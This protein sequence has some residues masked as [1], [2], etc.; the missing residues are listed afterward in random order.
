MRRALA[1]EPREARH[2]RGSR[3]PAPGLEAVRRRRRAGTE[4]TWR[5]P[6]G[7][8]RMKPSRPPPRRRRSPRGPAQLPPPAWRWSAR[9]S[10]PWPKPSMAFVRC[11][12]RGKR[13]GF[14]GSPS[15]ASG[16]RS[17]WPRTAGPGVPRGSP[18]RGGLR[19]SHRKPTGSAARSRATGAG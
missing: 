19:A 3:D 17:L 13:R 6:D 8:S 16:G 4:P 2:G 10:C 1:E 5:H 11:G 9:A 12:D 18:P 14:P 7:D 15:A